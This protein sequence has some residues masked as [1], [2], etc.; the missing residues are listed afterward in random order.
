MPEGKEADMRVLWLCNMMLP[1]I[2]EQFG[3]ESSN[4]EG[5]ISGLAEVTLQRRSENGI[6]LGIAFPAPESFLNGSG[7]RMQLLK[8][9]GQQIRCYGFRENTARP[10]RYEEVLE[11]RMQEILADFAPDIVHCFGTEYPH[12]LAMCRAFPKKERLLIGIQGLCTEIADTYFADLPERVIRSVTLRDFLKQDSLVQQQEKFRK[13][14][15]HETEALKLAGNLAG[16]TPWDRENTRKWNPN[17]RYFILNE[18]LRPDFYETKWREEDCEPHSIFVSQGDYPIK[19]LH[20]LLCAMPMLLEKYPDARVYV[21]GDSIVNE[22]TMK[23]KLKISAYGRYLRKLLR[24]NRLAGKVVF[25][26]RLDAQQMKEQYLRS[27][28]FVC[29]SAIEN[30]PNSLGEA[31]LLGMPCVSADVGGIPGIFTGG[32]DGILYPGHQPTQKDGNG[33]SYLKGISENLAKSI[34]SIWDNPKKT[35]WYRENARNHAEKNHDRER[36]YRQMT[37]IYASI[38]NGGEQN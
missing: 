32:E 11:E 23:E 26:G 1:M 16:R 36:N 25:L 29:C 20:Y 6:A 33:N 24:G 4:K 27:S 9:R 34:L 19:G 21:A 30:S 12:T 35:E 2:A 38:L 18:T 31:M 37:E 3:L 14:G 10:E 13:R 8:L 5:W 15:E 17:A 7:V 22:S 28:L